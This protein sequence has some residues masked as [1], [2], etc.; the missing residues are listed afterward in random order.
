M[1]GAP[2]RVAR[3]YAAALNSYLADADEGALN[4]AYELGRG[5]L[6]E[7]FGLLDLT[8]LHHEILAGLM[9]DHPGRRALDWLDPA[10]LFL[11]E[12]LSPFEM[13]LTGYREANDSLAG[14][15]R[16]LMRAKAETDDAHAR[17]LAEIAERE[18][19]EEALRQSQRLQAIGQLSGGIAHHFNNLLTVVMGNVHMARRRVA[20]DPKL[21]RLLDSA[22]VGAE[23]GAAVTRQL[24]AFSRRQ[25]LRPE[26]IDPCARLGAAVQLM[27]G[28][29][30]GAITIETDL[31]DDL[32]PIEIDPTE[33]DL[34]LI[35][36]GLNARDAMAG[37]GVLRVSA[38]N[39][40]LE[41]G[42][43]V[44][45]GDYLVV[46][47][48]DTGGGIAPENLLRV[49]DPFFTT[50]GAGGTG[51]GL[52]QVYGFAHQPGGEVAIDSRLGEGTVVRLFLPA[53]V[54]GAAAPPAT[55]LGGEAADT[56]AEAK[57]VVLVVDDDEGVASLAAALLEEFGFEVK[58]AYRA[59]AALELLAHDDQVDLLF[60]DIVM[61]DGM[62][63]IALA[64]AVRRL[65]P[66]LP[67]LLTT[68]YSD[69]IADGRAEARG[70]PIL[71]KPYKAGDLKRGVLTLLERAA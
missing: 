27:V 43:A 33:L 51:L 28:A 11:S 56:D 58:L 41:D 31:P 50:K 7:G 14:A 34:A 36:L 71:A 63:G 25:M 8:L 5:A 35:N 54:A 32:W 52:S 4:Q 13:T 19:A 53:L 24:L 68:G 70:F 22:A 66:D 49:F 18:R 1:N 62:D 40:H 3:R 17:L 10:A 29:L 26:P 45:A 60:S 6:A 42:Q 38:A 9:I 30:G 55:S 15:N 59:R 65:R 61:P 47:V 44:R 67:I 20:G 48:A 23:R 46:E 39:R 64:E 57:G 2:S 12:C 16:E 37:D 69:S 21:E